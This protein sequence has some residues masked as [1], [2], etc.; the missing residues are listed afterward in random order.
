MEWD[1]SRT[2]VWALLGVLLI[3]LELVTLNF[4]LLFFGGAALI[5]GLVRLIG[6]DHVSLEFLIFGLLGAAGV[7]FLRKPL[8]QA[9]P[10]HEA[11][12][13]DRTE[14]ILLQ[15]DVP[16]GGEIQVEYQGAPWTAINDTGH[17]LKSGTKAAISRV[18]GVRLFI[19]EG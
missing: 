5:T 11:Y 6:V 1:M 17:V 14:R 15:V 7:L 13:G 12:K 2:V 16:P 10:H 4:V 9:F 3:I 19:K 18:E 8:L